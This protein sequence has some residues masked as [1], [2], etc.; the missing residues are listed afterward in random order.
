MLCSVQEQ[1]AVLT[2]FLFPGQEWPRQ[3]LRFAGID[4]IAE[5]IKTMTPKPASD[6]QA[7]R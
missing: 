4:E 1:G 3:L 2:D 6:V 7:R 5:K